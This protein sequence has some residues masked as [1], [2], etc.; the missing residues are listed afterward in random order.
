MVL[1]YLILVVKIL[2]VDDVMFIFMCVND[3][4]DEFKIIE[5]SQCRF[6]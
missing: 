4:A 2:L 1:K 5:Y 6:L 3:H